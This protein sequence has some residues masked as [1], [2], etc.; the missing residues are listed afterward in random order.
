MYTLLKAFSVTEQLLNF[1]LGINK[2]SLILIIIIIIIY[3]IYVA[4]FRALKDAA[5]VFK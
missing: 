3:S 4:R 1:P 5:S 2:V